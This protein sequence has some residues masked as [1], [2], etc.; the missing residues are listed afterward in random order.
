MDALRRAHRPPLPAVR[1]RRRT[2][3]R[4][5]ASSLMGSGAETARETAAHLARARREGRRAAGA[6]VPAVLG[7][8]AARRAAGDVRAGRR[9][10][11]DQGAGRARRAALP[12]RRH[13]RSRTRSPSGGARDDAARDRRALRPVVE[14]LHP[15]MA[16]AVFDELRTSRAEE[17]LHRRHRRRRVAAPASPYDPLFDIE[18]PTTRTRRLL[19]PRRRRHG[20]RQQEQREDHRRGRRAATRR[21]T[22][23][24]TRTSPGA[25]T[26]SH[27][28]FGPRPIRAPYLIEQAN[29]VAC[30][31]FDFLERVDVL[32]RRR[33]APRSCSTVR[34]GAGRGVGPRCRARCS[35][36]H[37]QASC[38][39]FVDRR[40]GR[41]RARS[42]LG[43]RTN[44][45]LQTCFFAISGVLPRDEAI[46][47]D[48]DV[49]REDLRPTGRRGG[50][51]RTSRR[52]TG[53][54]ERLHEVQVPATATRR[55]GN[56]RRWCRHRRRSSCATVT[57]KMLAG[58]GDEIPV[59]ALPVDG[60]FPSRHRR[61]REAQ[62][63]RD[64]AASGSRTCASSA[65][66]A[67][68]S[69]RTA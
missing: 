6:P 50:A 34:Y 12:R 56:C 68:S 44:T 30:H 2:R 53:T 58:R 27:L 54:L 37:R 46:A 61:L 48:Q 14:G 20:R 65:A 29:F 39:F 1:L 8:G 32:G 57:A 41:S 43:G 9:A 38:G 60:T 62:H 28:R 3:R 63:R 7:R 33:R 35:S 47:H 5:G 11:A 18:P 24:T 26:I 23:S 36:D 17:R 49:D 66:N 4:A 51:R 31:Q 64:R 16:K 40:L 19:R 25:Q 55:P 42:G 21:A 10:R 52:S 13:R 69:A 67:A 45:I 22:S 59:S 15:A